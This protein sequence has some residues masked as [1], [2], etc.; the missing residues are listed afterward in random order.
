M[1][2][3]TI[4]FMVIVLFSCE[5]SINKVKELGDFQELPMKESYNVTYLRSQNGRVVNRLYSPHVQQFKNRNTVFP[6]G[7]KLEF[8]DSN[9]NTNAY[10]QAKY[11]EILSEDQM[12]IARDSVILVNF[13]HEEL[14]T[15]E[16]IWKQDSAK[17]YTDKY[18]KIKRN[19]VVIHGKGFESSED[20]STYVI[21]KVTGQYYVED[22]SFNEE[23]I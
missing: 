20:F 14:F 10:L 6:I 23:E 5:N 9:L 3:S 18:I 17:I 7:F 2:I 1:I 19:D 15:E 11:G 13:K 21:K 16:L 12:M 4:A 8:L 22:S